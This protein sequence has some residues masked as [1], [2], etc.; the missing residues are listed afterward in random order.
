MKRG[1][2][3]L[4]IRISKSMWPLRMHVGSALSEWPSVWI[5][6]L[7]KREGESGMTGWEVRLSARCP[8]RDE[9]ER[10]ES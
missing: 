8:V 1:F 5:L 4:D 10:Q 6:E 2:R 7:Q 3:A 9:V